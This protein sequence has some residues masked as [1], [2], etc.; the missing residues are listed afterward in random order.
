M[1]FDHEKTLQ[2]SP[3]HPEC[4]NELINRFKDADYSDDDFIDK[5]EDD[6]D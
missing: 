4:D 5:K 6:Y 2:S 3:S 1:I